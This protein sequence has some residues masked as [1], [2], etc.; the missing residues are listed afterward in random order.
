MDMTFQ[1]NNAFWSWAAYWKD[2]DVK[3]SPRFTVSGY[4][5]IRAG[6]NPIGSQFN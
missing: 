4:G 2:Y 6:L 1:L 5:Y 3:P